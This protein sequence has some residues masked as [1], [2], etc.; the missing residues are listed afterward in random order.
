MRSSGVGDLGSQ[1][2]DNMLFNKRKNK[3]ANDPEK[4]KY[5]RLARLQKA[6]DYC[7][8]IENYEK[9]AELKKEIDK[10]NSEVE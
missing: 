4:E 2:F 1:D 5:L 8:K 3:T 9:A 6:L 7:V 10:L